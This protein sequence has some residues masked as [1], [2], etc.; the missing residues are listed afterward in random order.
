MWWLM[1]KLHTCMK[2]RYNF[3]TT[4]SI[5]PQINIT[6]VP[7]QFESDGVVVTLE[8]I[9]QNSYLYNVSVAPLLELAYSDVTR[10]TFNVSYNTYYNVSVDALPTCGLSTASILYYGK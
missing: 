6:F 5:D 9:R 3:D 1:Y 2:L 10:I 8:W 7:E 4:A